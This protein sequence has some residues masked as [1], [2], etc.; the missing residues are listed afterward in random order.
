MTV[1]NGSTAGNARVPA[2]EVLLFDGPEAAQVLGVSYP[3]F[4]RWVAKGYIVPVE[5][6]D[7]M[8]RTLFHRREVERFAASLA[9]RSGVAS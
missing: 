7:G 5:V 1:A 2:D 8:R 6:P 9:G 4:R 3:T